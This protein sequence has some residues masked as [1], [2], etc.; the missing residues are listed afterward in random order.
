MNDST[1]R[2]VMDVARSLVRIAFVAG[3]L[4][5]TASNFDDTEATVIGGVAAA[6]FGIRGFDWS[7]KRQSG[8]ITEE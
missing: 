6:E 2:Y 5:M 8:E 3:V 4:W 1:K 7:R